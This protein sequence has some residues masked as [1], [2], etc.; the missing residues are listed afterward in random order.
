MNLCKFLRFP[1]SN[2]MLR[3]TK[4]I[5]LKIVES[6]E[7]TEFIYENANKCIQMTL[8]STRFKRYTNLLRIHN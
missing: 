8:F 6:N 4:R 1:I 5:L 2:S 7:W 3:E